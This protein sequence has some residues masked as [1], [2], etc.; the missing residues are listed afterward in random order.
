MASRRAKSG[1]CQAHGRKPKKDVISPVK[2]T[3]TKRQVD[4][5]IIIHQNDD[6][7]ISTLNLQ[8]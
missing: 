3:S 5:R 7:S 6:S 2:G 4:L 8:L 1:H